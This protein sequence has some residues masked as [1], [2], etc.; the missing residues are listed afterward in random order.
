MKKRAASQS[1]ENRLRYRLHRKVRD[2]GFVLLTKA[3]T[4]YLQPDPYFRCYG[5]TKEI[6]RLLREFGYVIQ[7]EIPH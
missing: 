1:P 2:Q 4:I 6:D 5:T 3:R 7:T